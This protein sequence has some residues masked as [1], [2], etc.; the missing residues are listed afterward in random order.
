MKILSVNAG[1]SSLKFQLLQMPEEFEI[2]SGV[3]ERIGNNNANSKIKFNGSSK[4]LSDLMVLDHS[5]AV[6]LVIK[7]LLENKVISSLDEIQGPCWW[8]IV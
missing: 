2:A 4:T 3:V 1:S 6:D 7:G 5:V 8:R